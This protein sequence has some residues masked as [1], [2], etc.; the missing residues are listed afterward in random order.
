MIDGRPGEM[1][2]K[3]LIKSVDEASDVTSITLFGL[4]STQQVT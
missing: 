3:T 1:Q 4:F 2:I